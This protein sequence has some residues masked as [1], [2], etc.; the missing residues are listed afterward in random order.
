MLPE[1]V[2]DVVESARKAMKERGLVGP[3]SRSQSCQD[4]AVV[5]ISLKSCV[6]CPQSLQMPHPKMEKTGGYNRPTQP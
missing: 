4:E 3:T 5:K 2:E 1:S 6:V